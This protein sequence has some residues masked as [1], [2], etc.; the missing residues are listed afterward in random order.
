MQNT[1]QILILFSG[2]ILILFSLF[3]GVLTSGAF[4]WRNTCVELK[5]VLHQLKGGNSKEENFIV[6]VRILIYERNCRG[7][8]T[9]VNRTNR[10][11]PYFL[12]QAQYP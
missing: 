10:G 2:N 12:S 11:Q 9:G 4:N 1:F 7:N 5:F 8:P 6:N 3:V